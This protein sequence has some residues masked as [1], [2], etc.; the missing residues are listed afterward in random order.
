MIS[1]FSALLESPTVARWTLVLCVTVQV[2]PLLLSLVR[3]VLATI[4]GYCEDGVLRRIETE[5]RDIA[6]ANKAVAKNLISIKRDLADLQR[7]FDAHAKSGAAGGR[8]IVSRK[9]KRRNRVSNRLGKL[10]AQVNALIV[11]NKKLSKTLVHKTEIL[12][13]ETAK[14]PNKTAKI[15]QL[16]PRSSE[17]ENGV[18]IGR[19]P[20]IGEVILLGVKE[21]YSADKVVDCDPDVVEDV[22][23]KT[24]V[25]RNTFGMKKRVIMKRMAADCVIFKKLPKRYEDHYQQKYYRNQK[26]GMFDNWKS[27]LW[28]T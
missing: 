17:V 9:P 2:V 13:N 7:A 6:K 23:K 20:Q 19:L 15:S 5:V 24:L 28:K 11:E 4:G 3:R 16:K 22:R 18:E 14:T 12:D 1:F 10:T 27:Y 8:S 21:S 25:V 26:E